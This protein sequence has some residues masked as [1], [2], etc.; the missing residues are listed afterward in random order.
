MLK[1]LVLGPMEIHGG[2]RRSTV[3]GVLQQTLLA[4]FLA[5]GEKLVTVDALIDE[6]WGTTPPN[7][8]GNAL[9]AQISRL[10]RN[11]ARMEPDRVDS[12]LITTTSGYRLVMDQAELDAADLLDTVRTV[13]NRGGVRTPHDVAALRNA[14][15]L[16]RGPTFGGIAGGSICQTASANYQE[17]RTAARVLL[18]EIELNSGE[19]SKIIPELSELVA[20][21][22]FRESYCGLLMVALYRSGRQTD[23]LSVARRLRS[24]LVEEMGIEPSP[25]LRGL[26]E[27]ILNHDPALFRPFEVMAPTRSGR[28]G[29]GDGPARED[30][31]P[32]GF[33]RAGDEAGQADS[34]RRG[35]GPLVPTGVG[36]RVP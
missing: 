36:T 11:L 26:E 27:A 5:S 21:Y 16:W 13:Q 9:H 10:R 12:R 6:L 22:P 1:F 32:R 19:H 17:Y 2:P 34:L 23:A 15:D 18:F 30:E 3:K 8:A 4:A 25:T 24:R 33:V 35:R 14:L 20:H 7:K 29:D 31:L 28:P